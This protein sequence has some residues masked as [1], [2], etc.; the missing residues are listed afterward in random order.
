[1]KKIT[2]FFILILVMNCSYAVSY[3]KYYNARF[4]YTIAYPEFL[5]LQEE[6]TNSDGRI[7]KNSTSKLIVWG[8]YAPKNIDESFQYAKDELKKFKISFVAR[9]N[10]SFIISGQNKNQI[11]YAK[12]VYRCGTNINFRL[13][14][15]KAEIKYFN[16]IISKISHSFHFISDNC[17]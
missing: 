5:V 3:Q 14:Y 17:E 2:L 4:G 10:N 8:S 13:Y 7:I 15:P 12:T 1:M 6:P 11:V 16:S 9:K